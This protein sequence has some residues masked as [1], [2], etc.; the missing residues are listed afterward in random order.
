MLLTIP[1]RIES[2]IVATTRRPVTW[3]STVPAVYAMPEPLYWTV[4]PETLPSDSN[5]EAPDRATR[6]P[7]TGRHEA[8]DRAVRSPGPRRT[9][10]RTGRHETPDR[11]VRS[12]GPGR[13]E[14]PDRPYEALDRAL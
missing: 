13:H 5:P 3:T 12:R 10:P 4:T 7:R 9:K 11:A 1:N 6:R 14:A 8:P 2:M